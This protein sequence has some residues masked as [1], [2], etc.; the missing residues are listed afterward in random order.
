MSKYFHNDDVQFIE[1]QEIENFFKRADKKPEKYL[2]I[3]LNEN[4]MKMDFKAKSEF[5]F[6]EAIIFHYKENGQIIRYDFKKHAPVTS[7]Y[8]VVDPEGI[9]AV[10]IDDPDNPLEEMFMYNP[11]EAVFCIFQAAES[12]IYILYDGTADHIGYGFLYEKDGYPSFYTKFLQLFDHTLP[13]KTE[14]KNNTNG[15]AAYR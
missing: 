3:A 2:R 1:S 5:E 9:M 7:C 15:S 6:L 11:K 13:S 8:A 12:S 10:Y 4:H 14:K